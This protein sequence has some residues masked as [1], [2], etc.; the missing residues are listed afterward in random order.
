[1][2]L[3]VLM[4]SVW[5]MPVKDLTWLSLSQVPILEHVIWDSGN[6]DFPAW[7]PSWT[8]LDHGPHPMAKLEVGW[9]G[10]GLGVKPNKNFKFGQRLQV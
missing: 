1:M 2:N 8:S 4:S 10:A 7:M 5:N 3:T 6:T 9:A